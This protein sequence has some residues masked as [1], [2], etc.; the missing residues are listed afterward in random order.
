MEIPSAWGKERE[1]S[2]PLWFGSLNWVCLCKTQYQAGFHRSRLRAGTYGLSLQSWPDTRQDPT[3]SGSRP[4]RWTQSPG[5]S[6]TRMTSRVP[7]TEL[8]LEPSWPPWLQASGPPQHQ[9]VTTSLVSSSGQI[10]WI[11]DPD[12]PS[13]K[14]AIVA[15][16]IRPTP[17]SPGFG[18]TVPTALG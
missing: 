9:L 2:T 11:Q 12:P 3:A 15:S 18:T 17:V 5:C 7:G 4:A 16:G 13:I 1:V 8:L 14:P 10:L 6:T